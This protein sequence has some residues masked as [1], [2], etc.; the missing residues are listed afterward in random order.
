MKGGKSMPKAFDKRQA[1]KSAPAAQPSG[2]A[3]FLKILLY[4][5]VVLV[6]LTPTYIA[7]THYIY[8]KK[9]PCKLTR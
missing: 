6:L 7:I 3:R 9:L 1:Q 2:K 8:Q 5:G 4:I